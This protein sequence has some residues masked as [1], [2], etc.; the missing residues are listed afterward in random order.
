MASED[1]PTL[2][3]IPDDFTGGVEVIQEIS[4]PTPWVVE[5][6][7]DVLELALLQWRPRKKKTPDASSGSGGPSPTT[8]TRRHIDPQK[9]KATS[10]KLSDQELEGEH[11]AVLGL[12]ETEWETTEDDVMKAY[13]KRCLETH[14][15]KSGGDDTEFKKVQL[16]YEVLSHPIKRRAYDSSLYF[17]D[18]IPASKVPPEKFYE[19]FDEVFTRNA[20]WSVG[21]RDKVPKLGD[22]S[23][24]MEEVDAFYTFWF[25]FKSWRDFAYEAA[26]HDLDEAE[27]RDERRWMERQNQ[28]AIERKKKAESKRIMTLVERAYKNDPRI[29]RRDMEKQAE[30]DRIREAK[31][32]EEEERIRKEQEEI[33]RQKREEEEQ[34]ALQKELQQKHKLARQAF[35]KLTKGFEGAGE[36]EKMGIYK[37][38]IDWLLLKLSLE[39][40]QGLHDQVEKLV[41]EEAKDGVHPAVACIYKLV[42]ETEQKVKELRTGAPIIQK[43]EHTEEAPKQKEAAKPGATWSAEELLDLQK[44]CV[45]YPA[46]T[47]DRWRKLSDFLLNSKSPDDCLKKVKQL[48][49]EYRMPQQAAAGGLKSVGQKST[50]PT[51]QKKA[52]NAGN[53]QDKWY[54]DAPE[55]T[56]A[57]QKPPAEETEDIWSAPQQKQLEQALRE[58][59]AYKEKDKWE[60]IA[61]KVE[62]KTKKQV[63]A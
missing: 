49:Q 59:K 29:K 54:N 55:R 27:G 63:V 12:Q 44:A 39:E 60:K 33:E 62:G 7:G 18:S 36:V 4:K 26:E 56:F 57:E 23:T 45:K 21:G 13:K 9:K 43:K 35:R 15:D 2:L 11:Y 40:L 24:P 52:D 46:G 48:E 32:K 14:P 34:K 53:E 41:G 38:D 42:A 47:V 8:Q 22:E 1:Q 50:L 58:L 61:E 20:K 17:D 19:E 3:P 16:A 31:R 37:Q 30:K 5:S 6:C 10:T 25:S 51:V 28:R